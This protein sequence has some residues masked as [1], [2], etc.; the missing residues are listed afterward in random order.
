M[1]TRAANRGRRRSRVSPVAPVSQSR[2]APHGYVDA[3][4]G[5]WPHEGRAADALTLV[6]NSP[7]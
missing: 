1:E 6:A 5:Q 3:T 7:A 4:I 2:L